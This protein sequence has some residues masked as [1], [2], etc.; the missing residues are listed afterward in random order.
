MVNGVLLRPLPVRDEQRIVEIFE[1]EKRKARDS[2]SMADA[3]DWKKR[4]RSF[5][6]LAIYRLGISNMSGGGDPA[7]VR[8]LECDP[9]LFKVL[10]IRA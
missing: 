4:L 3:L 1:S 7:L 6:S 9:D 5:E 8:T 2:V 10:G